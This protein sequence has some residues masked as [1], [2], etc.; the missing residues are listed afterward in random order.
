MWKGTRTGGDG[1][2]AGTGTS[3]GNGMGSREN[4]TVVG[5]G[6]TGGAAVA[7]VNEAL[8][9]VESELRKPFGS[10]RSGDSDWLINGIVTSA[11]ASLAPIV[12]LFTAQIHI[13]RVRLHVLEENW[14]NSECKNITLMKKALT[15]LYGGSES[16]EKVISELKERQMSGGGEEE[17][18]EDGKSELVQH[19]ENLEEQI[20]QIRARIQTLSENCEELGCELDSYIERSQ[21]RTVWVLTYVTLLVLPY[22]CITAFFGM[23]LMNADAQGT[24]HYVPRILMESPM[25]HT[26]FWLLAVI[27]T[28]LVAVPAFA[29]V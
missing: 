11:V 16:L 25:A 15:W 24:W 19:W 12:D 26:W 8:F 14:D 23:N 28:S 9:H 27:F 20:T 1:T 2:S 17:T 10:V 29:A 18:D 6:A 21:S 3:S 4:G 13:A 7:S 5:G 22:Q